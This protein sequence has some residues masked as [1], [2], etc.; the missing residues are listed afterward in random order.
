MSDIATIQKLP[1]RQVK[2]IKELLMNDNARGQLAAVAAKHMNPERMMRVVANAVRTTPQL[3]ECEP[4][5]MLGA[6]MTCA[7]LGLEP[8]TPL[9][10]AYLIPFKNTR[11]NV[12]EVQLIIGYKGY[13]DLA[14]RTGQ[15]TALHADVVYSDDELWS[16]E[17]GSEMHLKHKPGPRAGKK[18]HVYCHVKLVD[19]EAFVVLPWA[20]VLKTRDN[21]Q[22]WKTAVKFGKQAG[23]PWS[24]H[25]DRMGA[26]TAVRALANA[27]EMPLSIEFMDAI[28][29]D[30]RNADFRGL[31]LDP[32]AGLAADDAEVIDGEVSETKDEAKVVEKPKEEAK[33]KADPKPRAKAEPKPQETAAG[34]LSEDE[35]ATRQTEVVDEE[36]G[37]VTQEQTRTADPEQFKA[38]QEMILNDLIDTEPATIRDLYGD[39]IAQME[40]NAPILHKELMAQIEA[41]EKA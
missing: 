41:K 36:T 3:Q 13:A 31:A 21:S 35:L 5:S 16:Y 32:T 15:V 4:M 37:E 33:P 18:T 10:H 24:T 34:D 2:N 40:A 14:R 38:L 25:E 28:D 12:T 26:K 39:Q 27:G 9:G 8:N 23:S 19:G 1:L 17:Y 6:L 22:G 7:S 11:K 30:D 20:Q 29:A